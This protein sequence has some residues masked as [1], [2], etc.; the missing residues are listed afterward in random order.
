MV[1]KRV[2]IIIDEYDVRVIGKKIYPDRSLHVFMA[3]DT[4]F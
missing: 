3:T 1:L 4:H 2:M